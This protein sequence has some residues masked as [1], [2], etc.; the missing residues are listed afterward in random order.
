MAEG[1]KLVLSYAFKRLK[2]H[3]IEANVQTDNA[4]SKS[5]IKRSAFRYEG[6]APRYVNRRQMARPRTLGDSG[7]GVAW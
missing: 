6:L 3:R 2:L 1:I 5:L 7:R 4:K